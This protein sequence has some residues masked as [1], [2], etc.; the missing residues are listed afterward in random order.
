MGKRTGAVNGRRIGLQLTRHLDI[1]GPYNVRDLGG[2]PTLDGRQTPWKTFVRAASLHASRPAFQS[3][4]IAYGIRAVIDLR[5]THETREAPSVF[6]SSSQ[7]TYH[8]QNMIGECLY[9]AWPEKEA[10]ESQP[11]TF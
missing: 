5:T 2:Y 6:A 11:T 1:N 3:A 10:G 9:R 8:H 7:V 4:L